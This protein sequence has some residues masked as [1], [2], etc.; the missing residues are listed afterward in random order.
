MLGEQH[1]IVACVMGDANA[2]LTKQTLADTYK[3]DA[4]SKPETTS[5]GCQNIACSAV[6][7]MADGPWSYCHEDGK[8]YRTYHCHGQNGQNLVDAECAGVTK[9]PTER[10]CSAC[11]T[12]MGKPVIPT[13]P[14][15]P[16]FI[17]SSAS[18][19]APVSPMHVAVMF[20]ALVAILM[21]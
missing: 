4:A 7:W 13:V 17:G 11:A 3:C 20:V 18:F 5:S 8:Q 19:V 12:I 14:D 2:A 10:P 9:P 1:R 15:N 21:R 6:N 16:N